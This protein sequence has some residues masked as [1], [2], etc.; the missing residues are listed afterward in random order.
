MLFRSDQDA[1]RSVLGHFCTGLTVITT[2]DGGEPVGFTCQSFSS[3]SLDP[4][5]ITFSPAHTSTTWP[6]IREIGQFCVNILAEHHEGLSTQM[7][8]PGTG[9]FRGVS[10][11]PSGNGCPRLEDAA[12]WIDCTLDAEHDGGDHTIVVGRVQDL[13]STPHH[14]P[15]LFFRGRYAGILTDVET[16]RSVTW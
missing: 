15:L 13:G 14:R 7:S 11:Q 4:P 6:R 3:L 16:S 5:L 9:K 8:K 2:M 1:F 10:W 12:A